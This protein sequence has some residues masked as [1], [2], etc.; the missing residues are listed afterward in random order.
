ML[1]NEKC[2]I[3]EK[4]DSHWIMVDDSHPKFNLWKKIID[5]GNSYKETFGKNLD[6]N[7]ID[8]NSE[9]PLT[10]KM[11]M[12]PEYVKDGMDLNDIGYLLNTR[13]ETNSLLLSTYR[14]YVD[15]SKDPKQTYN[16][17]HLKRKA[18]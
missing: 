3:G 9:I 15:K 17:K 18:A 6:P 14:K 16:M 4:Y 10:E 1:F 12:I 5:N 7:I 8:R 13:S 2:K 11:E